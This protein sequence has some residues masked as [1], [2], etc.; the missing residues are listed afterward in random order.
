MTPGKRIFDLFCSLALLIFL[1][2]IIFI[3]S[4]IILFADGKPIFYISERMRSTSEPFN[5]IKFR[6]MTTS[7]EDTGVSGGNKI[8]RISRLGKFLRKTRLDELPQIFNVLRGDISFVGPRPPLRQYVDKFPNL[9]KEVLQSRP[10]ITG[11]AS[12]KYHKH[13]EKILSKCKTVEETDAIYSKVCIPRKAK[14]D[15]MYTSNQS[16]CFDLMIMLKTVFK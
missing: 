14:I 7:N 3:L 1:L 4:I 5:L 8:N 11:L 12:L 6:T 15:M 2:P 10:G 16:L 13:E 9:Y